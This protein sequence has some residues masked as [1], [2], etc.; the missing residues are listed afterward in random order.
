MSGGSK[1]PHGS[2]ESDKALGQSVSSASTPTGK[3]QKR[4]FK[5][6]E[7]LL[8]MEQLDALVHR[9]GVA[10]GKVTKIFNT[11]HSDDG[12]LTLTEAQVK[13]YTRKLE[14]AY[15]EYLKIQDQ[16]I[17]M[18]SA[19]ERE[20]HD[21]HFDTFDSLHDEVSIIL[22]EQASRFIPS[23]HAL[24]ANASQFQAV[25][26]PQAPVVVHQPLR[27]PIPTF[28]GR[29]E[30]WPKFKAMFKDLVDRGPDPPAVK[31]YHLD[32]S[33]I[34]SA[35]G[36]IDAKTINEGNYAHAW[37]LLEERYENKRHSIDNHIS[38]LLNLKRMSKENHSELRNLVDECTRHV[39]S[40]KY[41]E[42]E[43]TGVSEQILVHLLAKALDKET[44]RRW[45]TTIVHGEL[46]QYADTLKFLKDQCFVLERC[47]ST[48]KPQQTQSKTVVTAKP[49]SQKSY[50][51]T[52]SEY[53]VKCD[54]CS[55]PHANFTCSEFRSLSIPQRLAKVR[56][57][58]VCFNCLRKG[59]QG[60][61][62]PSDK[63]CFKCK[64][65]HHSL[66]HLE[67]KPQATEEN[68]PA[69]VEASAMQD[70][71]KQPS[72]SQLTTAT[73]SS[74]KTRPKQHVLLLTAVVDVIDA[75]CN[76]HPVRVLL[77]S[78]SQANLVSRSMVEI[79]GLKQ[80]PSNVVVA[81]VNN[82]K[83]HA[84]SS[85]VVTVHSRYSNFVADVSCLVTDKVTADLPSTSIDVG[86]LNLPTGV[87]LADPQFYQ[88]GK[89][90][91]LLGNQLFLKL[92]L[93]GEITLSANT[94]I[95]RETQFGWVVG[96]TYDESPTAVPVVHSHSV[97]LEDLKSSIERFWEVE[98][99]HGSSKRGSEEE[100]CEL[101]FQTTHRRDATGGYI[102]QLPLRDTISELG[103]SRSVA[104]R[105][106]RAMERR[107][108]QLPELNCRVVFDASAK[109]SGCSL[110][111]V[112]KVGAI[113]QS[114]LQSIVLR[115]ALFGFNDLIKTSTA[116][117][118]LIELLSSGGFHLHKWSS[119]SV[120]L[121]EK[122]LEV[123]REEVVSV[124]TNEAIKTLGLMWNPTSDE[125]MFISFPMSNTEVAT[126]RQLLSVIARMYDP[127]GLVAPVIVIGKLLMHKT[128]KEEIDWDD[129]IT[130]E[131]KQDV[132]NYLKAISGVNTIR[133]PRQ[134]VRSNATV[135]ELHGFADASMYAYGACIF[136]R[137]VVPG[138]QV[139]VQLLTAKSK[140]VPKSVLTVPR[141]E[142]LAALLLHRL[143]KKILSALN[144]VFDEI[145][146]WS[147]SQ[148]VLAW[149][150][151]NPSLLDVFVSNR[152]SEIIATGDKFRWCYINTK[153]NPADLVSRGVS[154]DKLME[155]NLWWYGPR[156]LRNEMY[157]TPAPEPLANEDVPE[158][159][160][161]VSVHAVVSLEPLPVFDKFESFRK[162]QRVLAYVLRFYRNCK[163]KTKMNRVLE[164][165]PTVAEL[166]AAM[167]TLVRVLQYQYL[168][169]EIE[170]VKAGA[171]HEL[172]E[173]YQLF[174]QQQTE[175]KI[176]EFCYPRQIRWKMIPPNAPHMGGL[177][178]A[179]VKSTKTI[180]RKICQSALLTMI[181]FVT[182]LCQI[183]ALLNSRPLYASSDDPADLEPLT[184]G[185]F[186]IG[187]PLN[188]IPEPTYDKIPLNRLSRWQY[189]H[190]LRQAF[191]KRWSR[192]YLMKLQTR[193]KW[194]RKHSN[195][196]K[197]MIVLVKEDNLP[198]QLWKMGRIER[199]YPG[200]DNMV[201]TV[202][203]RTKA[204][205][206]MRPIHKLAPLPILD[207]Q[208]S[209]DEV[210][211]S[212]GE[213]VRAV[214]YSSM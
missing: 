144:T 188:A 33:L 58:R 130:G 176:F 154:A 207:N 97:T 175:Q 209:G 38:G 108:A 14:A 72:Q 134:V 35:A 190:N 27:M 11:C 178:E 115:S 9:R 182:L 161:V 17:G 93:P 148:I 164:R 145:V 89:I 177:W 60:K 193:C 205:L 104:L 106:F 79:L 113:N 69:Q 26:V 136:I 75:N 204:G 92:I 212:P 52:S 100:E 111:D 110:D 206:L 74:S 12:T 118:Q 122:I 198:P 71:N 138:N 119:N 153:E 50:A 18:V 159:K 191:W 195:L 170:R 45:E 64:R 56:E 94:P 149:L 165:Y 7:K 37:Q 173:L 200:A 131:L 208:P 54:F 80:R 123:D 192:E 112:L 53:E 78:A 82:I 96:G 31:L 117:E 184:P 105:R 4:K 83:S 171:K 59:H 44:R 19:D 157:D 128:W 147:D 210:D 213:D 129:V 66:L 114:D 65:R 150:Q 23:S 203:L 124:G 21:E 211:D 5:L 34:G 139:A 125:L 3:R 194:T 6:Q 95:L 47:E 146:L 1:Q 103:D 183:E 199:T 90:H 41:L 25:A 141:K 214:T 32:K 162:L 73:C 155:N 140:I 36:L 101:H 8:I 16:I 42:Q 120:E 2:V 102:V 77:D 132:D 46:P 63:T 49:N 196:Q 179:G 143:V 62:C 28:D 126:K 201:R 88:K 181:E 91:M 22:E 163:E 70:E 169:D 86:S 168:A 67:E 127:L 160:G 142:L 29:Y 107:F 167:D 156:F 55:K 40:L 24:A 43:F 180:L 116:Q 20:P 121:L 135:V 109:V 151:K 158:L 186:A 202:E 172:H 197:D 48:T 76:S 98:D 68:S 137:S 133:I 87:R 61:N 166:R 84:S 189:V 15:A 185:D 152:V 99:V 13:V 51:I 187:R 81:G 174:K 30:S 85:C 10:K 39:E 57:K